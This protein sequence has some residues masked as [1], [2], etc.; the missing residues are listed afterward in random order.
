MQSSKKMNNANLNKFNQEQEY[1]QIKLK[2]QS[3]RS[4]SAAHYMQASPVSKAPSG[5]MNQAFKPQAKVR[6]SYE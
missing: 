3:Q 2:N 5:K 6:R 1:S 4:K